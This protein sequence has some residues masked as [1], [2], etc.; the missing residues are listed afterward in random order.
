MDF[1]ASLRQFCR[2]C[3][4][5]L[6]NTAL[7]FLVAWAGLEFVGLAMSIANLLGCAAATLLSY[8]LNSRFVFYEAVSARKLGRFALVNTGVLVFAYFA[9]AFVAHLKWPIAVAVIATSTFGVTIGY[10]AHSCITFRRRH[11]TTHL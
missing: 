4:A 3:I 6:G 7:H 10:V 8:F 9:G 11:Q 2:Y 5:G 1:S